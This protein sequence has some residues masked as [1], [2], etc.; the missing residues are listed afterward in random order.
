VSVLRAEGLNTYD[1]LR[2]AHLVVT[3]SALDAIHA[4]LARGDRPAPPAPE[5]VAEPAGGKS[6]SPRPRRSRKAAEGES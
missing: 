6:A 2:H 1:V 5:A 4:R 3:R